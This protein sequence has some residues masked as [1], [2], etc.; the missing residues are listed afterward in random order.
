[1]EDH[2]L[3]RVRRTIANWLVGDLEQEVRNRLSDVA[4]K[5]GNDLDNFARQLDDRLAV[6]AP[7]ERRHPRSLPGIDR[8]SVND[9]M[10]DIYR[11]LYRGFEYV[12]VSAVDGN[13]AEFG[14]SSGR[15]AMT[16]AKAMADIG[17]R[18]APSDPAHGIGPRKLYLFDSFEGFP[19]ATNAI[20][21]GAP[22]VMS[23]AWGPGVAK[24]ASPAV[25]REMCEAFLDKSRIVISE[26]WYRD[27][28]PNLPAGTKFALVHIDC[29]FYE[30]TMDVLERLFAIDAFADGC[31]I[32]FDDWYT[33][34]GS[35][36]F[37]EQ[38][39]WA[40]CVAKYRPRFTDWGAYATVGRRF[41]IHRDRG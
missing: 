7:P 3:D 20:D 26:G 4:Q 10:D 8:L 35:P 12:M 14:T 5:S 17:E 34:K 1:M 29:D 23:G 16:L 11:E 15:T 36:D 19:V 41:L 21:S 18:Y 31:A 13:V 37:G 9:G 39:A 28:M 32:Y 38:R 22:Q 27:T 40:D 2:I 30:S 24:D 33:N 25:L 6:L